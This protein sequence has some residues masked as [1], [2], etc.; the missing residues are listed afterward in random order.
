MDNPVIYA[1]VE[2]RLKNKQS[3]AIIQQ[4]IGRDIELK[5][6]KDAIYE[7]IY[8]FRYKEWFKFLTRKKV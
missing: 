6:G 1:Y 7:Y 5:I 2:Y 3:P 8:R 4:D